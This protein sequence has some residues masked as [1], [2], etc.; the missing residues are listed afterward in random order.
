MTIT[1]R[2]HSIDVRLHF[3]LQKY[4]THGDKDETAKIDKREGMAVSDIL[5]QL[6]VPLAEVGLVTVAHKIVDTDYIVEDNTQ[7]DIYPLFAGG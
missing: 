4:N 6:G 7:I 1:V 3:T 2:L 5:V